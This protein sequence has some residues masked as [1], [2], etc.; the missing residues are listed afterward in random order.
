MEAYTIGGV[1]FS[2]TELRRLFGLNSTRFTISY[3]EGSFHFDVLGFGHRVGLS[4]YGAENMA[5]QGF[6][7]RTILQYYYQG[8]RLTEISA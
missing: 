6:S 1:P 4:Q 8:A 2:G 3:R 5:K 7:Y